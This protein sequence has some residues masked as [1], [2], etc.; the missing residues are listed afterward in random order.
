M[1][2]NQFQRPLPVN[3]NSKTPHSGKPLPQPKAQLQQVRPIRA[4]LPALHGLGV[5]LSRTGRQ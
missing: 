4:A 1:P 3:R 2:K 5:L